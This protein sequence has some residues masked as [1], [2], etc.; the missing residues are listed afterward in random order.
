MCYVSRVQGGWVCVGGDSLWRLEPWLREPG[1]A[2]DQ[3]WME[4]QHEKY[5]WC[6]IFFFCRCAVLV[7][8]APDRL[9]ALDI[10]PFLLLF[11]PDRSSA[12]TN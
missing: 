7:A 10:S 2:C 8:A 9:R 3:S 11:R 4:K 6:R 1:L 5:F 12:Q